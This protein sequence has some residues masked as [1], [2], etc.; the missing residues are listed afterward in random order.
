MYTVSNIYHIL[1]HVT[2]VCTHCTASMSSFIRVKIR[3]IN[4]NYWIFRAFFEHNNSKFH[5][6]YVPRQ[7]TFLDYIK[8][9]KFWR[10]SNKCTPIQWVWFDWCDGRDNHTSVRSMHMHINQ[11]ILY[12][13]HSSHSLNIFNVKTW[14]LVFF[15]F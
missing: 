2:V 3:D 9:F 10:L 8:V 7:N 1:L 12:Y 15:F 6:T 4:A 5:I 11:H 13:Y 14:K